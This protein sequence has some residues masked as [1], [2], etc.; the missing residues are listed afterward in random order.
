MNADKRGSEEEAQKHQT[1]LNEI[2][3]I[4]VYLRLIFG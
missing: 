1:F 2:C 3:V 4:C